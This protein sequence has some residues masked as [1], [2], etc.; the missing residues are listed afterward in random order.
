MVNYSLYFHIPFCTKKCAYCHFYV[1]PD[2]DRFKTL[3]LEML[4]KEWELRRSLISSE[5]ELLSIYFGG[6]TPALL[7]PRGIETILS[8]IPY[9]K[10][11]EITLEANPEN[12]TSSQMREFAA[13]G[14]NRVS[15]GVQTLSDPLLSTLSRTHSA[16][17]AIQAVEATKQAGIDNISIDLM[18]DIPGQS[19]ISW[20][21]SLSRAVRLPITHLS[22]YN[23]TIEPHT[24]FYKTR[25]KQPDPQT[26][27]RMLNHAIQFLQEKNF[28][29]YEISAFAKGGL[30]STHNVGYWRARPFLGLGPSAFSY[31]KGSRFRNVPHLHRWAKKLKNGEDPVDF[32]EKLLPE[33]SM[34]EQLAIGLRL[35]SGVPLQSWPRDIE[36]SLEALEEEKLIERLDTHLRLTQKGLL[37]HDTVAERV[38]SRVV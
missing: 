4:Q 24:L 33:E 30:F 13:L 19:L 21:K 1:I 27:L 22:L 38:L 11:C 35:L 37:F 14:I 16:P 8:W 23:L 17:C 34:K 18:Y 2:Q 25:P 15:I 32:Q 26:S 20:K 12:I 29:R 9:P 7:G 36:K 3:Y 31:W 5:M 6:G 28:E 10:S